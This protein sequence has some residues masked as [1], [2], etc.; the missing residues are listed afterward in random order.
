MT[1]K[2]IDLMGK[3]FTRLLVVEY[4][5]TKHNVGMWRRVC[6]CG[7][8]KTTSQTNLRNGDAK[9]CGCL[10]REHL[11]ARRAAAAE[12][13]EVKRQERLAARR[14]P[15]HMRDPHPLHQVMRAWASI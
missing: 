1:F 7:G 8:E 9:S 13:R 14:K 5:G 4:A 10:M 3:R 11:A 2:K 6:D 12:K 15:L